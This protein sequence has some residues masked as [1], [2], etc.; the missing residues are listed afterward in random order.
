VAVTGRTSEVKYARSVSTPSDLVDR[1]A[2]PKGL[3]AEGT[4]SQAIERQR[5]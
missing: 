4:D 2:I 1:Q 3:L 5:R